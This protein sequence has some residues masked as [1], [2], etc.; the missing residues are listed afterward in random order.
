MANSALMLL[1][2]LTH[3]NNNVMKNMFDVNYLRTLERKKMMQFNK[4]DYEIMR[5]K[6]NQNK[7]Q[8]LFKT[9]KKKHNYNNYNIVKR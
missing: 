4:F 9:Y 2:L 6:M 1:T 8:V 3:N 5:Y 7:A